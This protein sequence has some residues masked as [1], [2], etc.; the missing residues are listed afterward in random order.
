MDAF[1][2]TDPLLVA[3]YENEYIIIFINYINKRTYIN[4]TEILSESIYP[5]FVEILIVN[6]IFENNKT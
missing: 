3:S 6:Y 2:L 4:R 1:S 5:N